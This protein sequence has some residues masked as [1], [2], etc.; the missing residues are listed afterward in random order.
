MNT[1][2][3]RIAGVSD[4]EET[5]RARTL[6]VVG[7]TGVVGAGLVGAGLVVGGAGV[8][9]GIGGVGGAGEEGVALAIA[10]GIDAVVVIGS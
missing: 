6:G 8:V 10:L 4:A 3:A 5:E 7:G 9:G 2:A 1:A